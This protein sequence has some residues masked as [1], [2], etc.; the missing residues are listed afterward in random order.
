MNPP[1][2]PRHKPAT[3]CYRHAAFL[4]DIFYRRV[5][6]T[7]VNFFATSR[8]GLTILLGRVAKE[9][10]GGRNPRCGAAAY[11]D[12]SMI[13]LHGHAALE[14][15]SQRHPAI[16]WLARWTPSTP[17]LSASFLNSSRL[18]VEARGGSTICLFDS[19]S[20]A[21]LAAM[22]SGRAARQLGAGDGVSVFKVVQAALLNRAL[23]EI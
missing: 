14:P 12:G 18:S 11:L 13:L 10:R 1:T 15:P 16:Q 9:D 7:G 5:S 17:C 23:T 22:S 6:A 8:S 20:A 19:M 2:K 21:P 3:N 4:C